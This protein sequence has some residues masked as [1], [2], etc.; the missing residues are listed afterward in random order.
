MLIVRTIFFSRAWHTACDHRK[1]LHEI[2]IDTIAPPQRM[3]W[4]SHT[5]LAMRAFSPHFGSSERTRAGCP[6]RDGGGAEV[7]N[8]C[9]L[10]ALGAA[11]VFNKFASKNG[12]YLGQGA[13]QIRPVP[14]AIFPTSLFLPGVTSVFCQL[15]FP[16]FNFHKLKN[17]RK[18]SCAF[19]SLTP[20]DRKITT[21]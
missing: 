11:G 19:I 2:V 9:V 5:K 1:K 6:R 4:K 21:S 15:L 18:K 17:K 8:L 3:A 10:L 20:F 14:P 12:E 13:L 16:C 7:E